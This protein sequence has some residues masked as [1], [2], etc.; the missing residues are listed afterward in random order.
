M[1][2]NPS[3]RSPRNVRG[4][5]LTET[6]M[7][8]GSLLIVMTAV[9]R[10]GII[11]YFQLG[12]EG[13][14]WMLARQ[15]ALGDTLTTAQTNT[16]A[17]TFRQI[18][19][20]D[21]SSSTANMNAM[22]FPISFGSTTSVHGGASLVLQNQQRVATTHTGVAPVL[23]GATT[24]HTSAIAV[25]G[26]PYERGLYFNVAETTYDASNWS[27][28][29]DFAGNPITAGENAAPY[30]ITTNYMGYCQLNSS[31]STTLT[32]LWTKGSDHRAWCPSGDGVYRPLG[33][34]E[35]LDAKNWDDTPN[36][37]TTAGAIFST[38]A[39]HQRYYA[40]AA[41]LIATLDTESYSIGTSDIN[42][43]KS[44]MDAS[45]NGTDGVSAIKTIY[46]W[47]YNGP[48]TGYSSGSTMNNS[49]PLAPTSGCPGPTS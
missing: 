20:A 32:T 28:V 9:L 16:T 43:I 12:T 10:L 22:W 2:H 4:A 36:G 33:T 8:L 31:V 7:V 46:S 25:E 48:Y 41:Q 1:L 24:A 26:Q 17:L 14:A 29:T 34:A 18:L 15:T 6:A 3:C 23:P 44:A 35:Y 19:N 40:K 5:A 27:S 30:F 42:S 11:S 49:F 13:T 39:C 47:D 37:V 21:S 38:I 45:I